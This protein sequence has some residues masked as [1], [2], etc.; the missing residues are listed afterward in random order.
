MVSESR[1]E[2]EGLL[3]ASEDIVERRFHDG[4]HAEISE[5][6]AALAR[7][8]DH[9]LPEFTKVSAKVPRCSTV[10]VAR[11]AYSVSARLI[12]HQV[13][14]RVSERRRDLARRRAARD[15]AAA[16]R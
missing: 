13:E 12:G 6:R 2:K 11:R 15:D 8:P 14:A 10:H 5:E 7:L 9:R 4:H 1:R 3:G 16:T